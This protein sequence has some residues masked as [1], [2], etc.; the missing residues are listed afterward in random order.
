MPTKP[1]S[2][3]HWISRLWFFLVFC[4]SFTC[5]VGEAA[6]PGPEVLG[7]PSSFLDPI[8]WD[9]SAPVD[10]CIGISNPAGLSN[11]LYTLDSLPKGWWHFAETQASAAQLGSIRSYVR[12]LS[13]RSNRHLRVTSGAAAPL[14][15]GSEVA[16]AWTG[17]LSVCDLA[18]R[19]ACIPWPLGAYETGRVMISVAHHC[20]IDITAATVYLPP[21]GPT[22]PRALQI[23]EEL[24]EPITEQI[25][26]GRDGPRL[27]CGDFNQK[28]GRLKATQLWREYGW[29]EIQEFMLAVHQVPAKPTRK[30]SSSPDQ[31]WVSPQLAACLVNSAVWQ[32]YPDHATVV[33]GLKLPH[34]HPVELHWALPGSIPWGQVSKDQWVNVP[35]D[36]VVSASFAS[37]GGHS[38]HSHPV[39]PKFDFGKSPTEAFTHWCGEFESR[40]SACMQLDSARVDRSYHGRGQ[41]LKP[42]PRRPQAPVI[43]P[44]RQGEVT[45][46]SSF[47]NRA[48]SN[49][50][51]QLRRLQSY[52]HAIKSSR[53]DENFE[54]RAS[55]CT[56]SKL[57]MGFPMD[58]ELGGH[59]DLSKPRRHRHLCQSS[60]QMQPLQTRLLWTFTSTIASSN[61]GKFDAGEIAANPRCK[62]QPRAFLRPHGSSQKLHW[63]V[64]KREVISQPI[65]VVNARD[66]IVSVPAPF[67]TEGIHHWTLQSQHAAVTLSG[68]N[69]Q[70]DSD[71][72]L[73]EGQ[74]LACHV[75]LH[76][77]SDIHQKLIDLWLPRWMKH[78]NVPADAW[79]TICDF[80]QEHLPKGSFNLPRLT[81]EDWRQAVRSFKLSAATGP[82][83]W[84]RRDLANMTDPQVQGIL[85]MFHQIECTARWPDQLTVGLIHLL[86]KKDDCH[87]V[88]GFRPTTVIS[89][90]YRVYAGIRAGQLLSQI[91]RIADQWQCGFLKGRQATDVWFFISVCVELSLQQQ[92][93]VSGF[94]ADLAK[95]YNCLPRCPV[96]RLLACIG[97]PDWFI[98]CWHSHLD[99]FRRL[100]VVRGACSLPVFAKTG[101]PE[102][103]PLSCVA[104]CVIDLAWHVWQNRAVPRSICLSFVDNL[105]V[106][107]DRETD[108]LQ[109]LEA[110]RGFCEALDVQIDE[111]KLYGWSTHSTERDV[112]RANGLRICL[113][114]R[115]LGG[116]VIYCAK[117]RNSVI[118]DR[119]NAV[120]P[121]CT[122]LRH[123]SLPVAAKLLNVLCVLL[124]R[125]LHACESIVLGNAHIKSLRS[126]FMQALRWNRGGLLL[127]FV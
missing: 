1:K 25:V 113:S 64:W 122:K 47:L 44:S 52:Q 6:K 84:S 112:L 62:P 92:T 91:S 97:V 101:Y 88:N 69:F 11:K 82:C 48:V 103:C 86:Q 49:W 42:T 117:L 96:R 120:L 2:S 94:V 71:L 35:E 56:V 58:F 29:V 119:I 110:F 102:G 127:S 87:D 8:P 14:R 76:E 43:R 32:I 108:L 41:R 72:V 98:A 66:G 75:N 114:E 7:E 30:G 67:P 111:P 83:G 95:A 79:S 34:M 15:S 77:A 3:F 54:S 26:V 124:P 39:F 93:S 20:G 33:A 50:F 59:T 116:Q 123:A 81:I 126:G 107:S 109:S 40:V 70:V 118:I 16:G 21:V 22:H 74:Q 24:L 115:D 27:I 45:P 19:P 28:P 61:T 73:V 12:S 100:F 31:I 17:V 46:A 38:L 37:E 5:R 104:M 80:A 89:M 90:M 53:A 125:A 57:P 63:I 9:L 36:P 10:F 23:A 85:D 105:E 65:R 99:S 51:R 55:L 78:A 121:F 106:V 18:M 60:R 4:L 68:S 13:F